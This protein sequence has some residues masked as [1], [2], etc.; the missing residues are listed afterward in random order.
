MEAQGDD[1]N[2]REYVDVVNH[3][4]ERGILSKKPTDGDDYGH[5]DKREADDP[6]PVPD[7]RKVRNDRRRTGGTGDEER[8]RRGPEKAFHASLLSSACPGNHRIHSLRN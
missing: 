5:S 3:V 7:R 8:G 6:E 4:L 1:R 2:D